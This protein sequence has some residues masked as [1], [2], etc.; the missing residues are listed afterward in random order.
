M[1]I[2]CKYS[3]QKKFQWVYVNKRRFYIVVKYVKSQ[4]LNENNAFHLERQM[5]EFR[6]SANPFAQSRKAVFRQNARAIL[7][8]ANL[9]RHEAALSSAGV[10]GQGV[11]S[12]HAPR[13][14]FGPSPSSR[15]GQIG[16]MEHETVTT[17][18]R[19]RF[20]ISVSNDSNFPSPKPEYFDLQHTKHELAKLR[21]SQDSWK[22]K[23]GGKEETENA[24]VN[25][26]WLRPFIGN[27]L[28]RDIAYS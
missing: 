26:T 15:L 4:N 23:S 7:R 17:P 24:E 12:G 8:K 14:P 9:R 21:R 10:V 18:E 25:E 3:V 13:P 5:I 2:E 20:L 28:L 1:V 16:L 22:R 19:K 6:P 11:I 27:Y